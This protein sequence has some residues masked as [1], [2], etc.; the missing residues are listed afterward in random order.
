MR[1]TLAVSLFVVAYLL[2][3]TEWVHRVIVALS[4]AG[5]V[6]LF[7]LLSGVEAFHSRELGIDWNV[8]FLLLAMMVIVG[9]LRHT[10]AFEYLAIWSTKRTG[11]RPFRVLIMLIVITSVASALLDNVT[12]VILVAPVTVLIA[13][14]LSMPPVPLLIAEAMASNIGGTATLIGDPPNIIIGSRGG[15]SYLD[16]IVNLGPLVVFL[17]LVFL[18]LVRWV[19]RDSFTYRPERVAELTALDEREALTDRGLLA[20]ALAVLGIVTAGFALQDLLG[21]EPSVVAL[22]GAGVLLLLARRDPQ[23]FLREVEWPTLLFFIG[24]FVMVGALVKVG[25]VKAL[26]DGALR[27][28]GGSLIV[29]TLLLVWVSGFLSALV[30]NIPYVATTA[31][32]VQQ[33]TAEL[34]GNTTVLWWALALGADLG[35]NAT[36][37]GASANVVILGVAERS[38]HRIRFVDFAKYGVVVTGVTLAFSSLYLW[39]RYL[40]FA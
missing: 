16:F 7:R 31:P 5:L 29:A 13:D 4:G 15:L 32:L 11:G 8:I 23:P 30:D 3:A 36:V 24:L 33:L 1:Q 20:R 9:V 2:I 27:A 26:A 6:L 40:A 21:Y 39:V 28:T 38:G 17:M 34:P 37:I 12:T 19:F 22:L 25:V 18:A 35:G 14:R 10:G